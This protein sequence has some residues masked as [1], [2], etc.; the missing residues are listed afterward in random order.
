MFGPGLN[1]NDAPLR[2]RVAL[3]VLSGGGGEM[4]AIAGLVKAIKPD[5]EDWKEKAPPELSAEGKTLQ[6]SAADV[7]TAYLKGVD[8]FLGDDPLSELGDE[9][10]GPAIVFPNGFVMQIS[11]EE[12]SAL[13]EHI[14]HRAPTMQ[15][16]D[17]A[18]HYVKVNH[19]QVF[20]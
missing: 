14:P 18:V 5:G 4:A 6:K 8:N 16:E 15:G 2:V 19:G 10:K 9:F 17:G 12:L 7:V 20:A 1:L 11:A 13:G 3:T